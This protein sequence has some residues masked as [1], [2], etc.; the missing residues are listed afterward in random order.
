MTERDRAWL[1]GFLHLDAGARSLTVPTRDVER[2]EDTVLRALTLLDTQPGVVL[3]DEVGMGKTYEALGVIAARHHQSDAAKTLVLTPGPDL[4]TKWEKEFRAFASGDSAMYRPFA[5]QFEAVKT[6]REF[7]KHRDKKIIIAPVTMFQ[8]ARAMEHNCYLL[9]LFFVWT[10]VHH[11]TRDAAFRRY[12]EAEGRALPQFLP[13]DVREESFLD[14][15]AWS[16]I[17]GLRT[18]VLGEDGSPQ[19]AKITESW[20]KLGLDYFEN[21]EAVEAGLADLRFRLIRELIPEVDLLVI[22]EAHKLKN[23]ASV[24][25]TAVRQIFDGRFEKALFLTATPFQLEVDELRQVLHLFSL[26]RSASPGEAD[27]AGKLLSDIG[28]YKAAYTDFEAAWRRLDGGAD[29]FREAFLSD[30]TLE[31]DV[32]SQALVH[33]VR[34]AR[35]LL[36]L[37]RERIEPGF[38]QWMIRSLRDDKRV[39]RAHARKKLRPQGGEALPFLLYE[40]LIAQLF[41]EKSRTHKAAVQ[42]NMVS[43]YG[44]AREGDLM[45]NKETRIGGDAEK[46]RSVLRGVLNGIRD[47]HDVHPKLSF[48]VKDALGAALRQEKTLIFCT[49][50]E[51]LRELKRQLEHSWEEHLVAQWREVYPD[52]TRENVFDT[53]EDDSRQRGHHSR[54]RERFQR[55][56]SQLYV[57]LRE[58]YLETTVPIHAYGREHIERVVERANEA[59]QTLRVTK[60]RA[61]RTDWAMI[62]RCV[63]HATATLFKADQQPLADIDERALDRL[64]DP[65]FVALGYNLREDELEPDAAGDSTPTWRISV[66]QA[67]VVLHPEPGLWSYLTRYLM[68][69]PE[70]LRVRTVEHLARYLGSPHVP[71]FVELLL[72]AKKGGF[73]VNA[74]D[75]A[76]LFTFVHAFWKSAVGRSWIAR[77]NELLKH[78]DGLD[79]VRREELLESAF[80]AG[81]FVR[82]TADGESRERL[83][84]AFNTPLFPMVLVA[85]EVMQEGLDLHHHCARVV[86]HDLAWNPAQLEQ[87]VGRV[88]RLGSRLQKQ[89]ALNPDAKLDVLYP[90]IEGTID[91]RLDRTVRAREKWMEFLLGAAPNLD[92]YAL[93]DEE[94]AEL[95]AEFA[96]ALKIDLGPRM[97]GGDALALPRHE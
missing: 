35:R 12:R 1:R 16:E 41:Q 38:R 58:K 67:S 95:P 33:V 65:T 61:E 6:L 88:D 85:N 2:Q 81:Q 51:S 32:D 74:M 40:R 47:D 25:A 64:V 59:L 89:R 27:R 13:C 73:D 72:E 86:H 82:H 19:R 94:V 48:V 97:E 24:R 83:R 4:N 8:G 63:E 34:E 17:E 44:A 50:V 93:D 22:D 45:Q 46:Y 56:D 39:Y 69:V 23:A 57:V 49:R 11:K 87:R 60:T 70:D 10:R 90:L 21:R 52:A 75:T 20:D 7:V 42:I 92:E 66:D 28:E 9:S 68:F 79:E 5:G 78:L 76:S 43:S 55:T 36:R 96:E 53:H 31:R 91:I 71:F 37:K 29:A 15:V 18:E 84:E 26:A 14:E 80:S 3:A 62:K 54:V 30:P 77:I